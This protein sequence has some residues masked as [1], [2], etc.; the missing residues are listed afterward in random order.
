[1]GSGCALSTPM[2]SILPVTGST[3]PVTSIADAVPIFYPSL[4][5]VSFA[6]V[7]VTTINASETPMTILMIPRRAKADAMTLFD[8]GLL[9]D[10]V[11]KS[12]VASTVSVEASSKVVQKSSSG[13]G[14]L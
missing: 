3:S 10:I 1:M 5:M 7:T 12:L 9:M 13:K 11:A 6:E 4:P 2:H 14:L 8:P